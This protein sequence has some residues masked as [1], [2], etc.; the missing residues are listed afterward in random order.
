NNNQGITQ[1]RNSTPMQ[2][3]TDSNMQTTNTS[4]GNAITNTDSIIDHRP[5]SLVNFDL[6]GTDSITG[7][8]ASTIHHTR[9]DNYIKLKPQ[10]F[11]GSD[12]DFEDFLTQFEITAEING[13]NYKAK[14][15]YLAN[16]LT[17]AARA[18]LNEL[19]SEQRR[20]YQNLVQKL[21]ERY[22]SE[23]RA[24]VYRSQLKSRTKGKGETTAQLAQ[25]VRKLTRQAYP[26]VSLDVVEALAVDHF[27]DAIP[28][29]EIRLRLRE[30]G[31]STLAEAE[32]IAVRMESQ[33]TADK[34]RTRFVGKVE[35]SG[36]MKGP[37]EI[38][39][40]ENQMESISRRIDMLARS[41]Q[42]LSHRQNTHPNSRNFQP[43]NMYNNP[44][45]NRPYN[46]NFHS[47]RPFQSRGGNPMINQQNNARPQGNFHQPVQGS[48]T[49][50]N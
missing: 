7:T 16:S 33:R 9:A 48:A 19:T 15:L 23:N 31:P 11:T 49:R 25:G 32:R 44:R 20:D 42:N 22:G 17:G 1:L 35:Q 41:V 18:I 29:S 40:T 27:I 28:E 46:R 34:L 24:E 13:W 12:D 8:S 6:H 36:Q 14:S 50:L 2:L 37:Q 43:R 30:V 5:R 45:P 26:N 39:N 4:N 21:T 3:N 10:T 47:Q 38:Q